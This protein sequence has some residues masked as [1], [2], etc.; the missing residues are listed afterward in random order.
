MCISNRSIAWQLILLPWLG[1]VMPSLQAWRASI[2]HTN[3]RYRAYLWMGCTFF[4]CVQKWGGLT[5]PTAQLV[6][7]WRRYSKV[8]GSDPT[9]STVF[10][11]FSFFPTLAKFLSSC[12]KRGELPPPCPRWHYGPFASPFLY[13]FACVHINLLN[14]SLAVLACLPVL[15]VSVRCCNT[16]RK[17]AL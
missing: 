4:C 8:V 16:K 13:S 17:C 14:L 5:T 9:Q 12:K 10:F 3:W 1:L 2:Q 15:E 6:E 11:P 7:H